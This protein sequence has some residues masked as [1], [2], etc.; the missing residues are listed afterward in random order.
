MADVGLGAAVAARIERS[1]KRLGGLLTYLIG[2]A[3]TMLVFHGK[4]ATVTVDGQVIYD[5]RV[6][7]VVLANGRFHAGGMRMAPMASPADGRF[8]VLVLED[9]PRPVLL[10]SLLPRVYRGTHISHPKVRHCQGREVTIR[11]PEPLLLEMDGE[12]VGTTDVTARVVPGAIALRVPP[13]LKLDRPSPPDLTDVDV[14][15]TM[16]R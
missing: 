13:E 2:A 9:V 11:A 6:G 15:A 4:P 8:E 3:S 1:S 16:S 14:S 12:P 10:G 7:M 5:G